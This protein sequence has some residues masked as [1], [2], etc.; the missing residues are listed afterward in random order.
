MKDPA[1]RGAIL[2]ARQVAAHFPRRSMGS[3]L[4]ARAQ[5]GESNAF[6]ALIRAALRRPV[7]HGPAHPSGSRYGGG[8]R[9][10]RHRPML[11][12]PA[13]PP[14]PR[15]LRRMAV[16]AAGQRLPRPG[17]ARPATASVGYDQD[18][19]TWRCRSDDYATVADHDALERAFLRLPAD[20]R[21]A[22]VLTHY[23]GYSAPE[24][25]QSSGYRPEPSTPAC[26]TAPERC[27]APSSQSPTRMPCRQHLTSR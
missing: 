25:A 1:H 4:V 13:R 14:R 9:P 11:A 10:G 6:D 27:A 7:C 21:I 20:Q 18:P 12:R 2:T 16:S 23:V 15:S 8:R 24:V 3:D 19:K 22:L 5:R 17:A 26:T